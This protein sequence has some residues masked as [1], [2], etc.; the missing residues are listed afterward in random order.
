MRTRGFMPGFF[1]RPYFG[2]HMNEMHEKWSNMTSEEKQAFIDERMNCMNDGDF[3]HNHFF[4]GRRFN[5]EDIDKRCEEWMKKTSEEKE[6]FVKEKQ[7][8]MS[9][10]FDRFGNGAEHGECMDKMH[11]RWSTMTSEEKQEFIRK[12]ED[13]MNNFG[14]FFG[15]FFSE[16]KGPGSEEK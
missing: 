9:R 8:K 12:K 7:E 11:E 4:D 15:P 6:N 5:V 16:K 2:H 10:F 14:Y 1:G 3:K 13:V